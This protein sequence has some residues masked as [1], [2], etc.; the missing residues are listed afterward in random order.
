LKQAIQKLIERQDLSEHE[1]VAVMTQIMEGTATPAQ[2]AAL[3][4]AMRMKGE[5]IDEITGFARVMREFAINVP[6]KTDK[7]VVDTCGTGG[8]SLKTFNVST[9]AALIVASDGRLVVAKHG[10]RAATSKC[11]S[12]DVLEALG[13]RLDLP[14]QRIGDCVET[15]GIGFLFARAM[16]P[17]FKYA[18]PVRTDIGI[19]TIFNMLGP[20]TN[21]AGAPVQLIGVYDGAVCEALAHVL[22]KLGSHRALLV[23]GLEG[24]DEISTLGKTAISELRD[25]EVTSYVLDAEK[26]LGI[27]RTSIEAIAG[28]DSPAENAEVLVRILEGDDKGPKRDIVLLNAAGVLYVAGVVD[29]LADGLARAAELV[30]NGAAAQTLQNLKDFTNG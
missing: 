24:L 29:T 11:G 6:V 13:V 21:P 10:N 8:D 7:V 22:K 18:G 27:P 25:G 3:V 1:A 23:H 28:C 4:V 16:H 26:D 19:R 30:D 14:P 2:I 20:L 12:A 5:T 15:V 17:S 9:A